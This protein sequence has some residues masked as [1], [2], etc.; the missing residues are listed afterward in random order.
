MGRK[1]RA[2]FNVTCFVVDAFIVRTVVEKDIFQP[3][4]CA[5]LKG[6]SIENEKSYHHCLLAFIDET[7]NKH[8]NTET[9]LNLILLYLIS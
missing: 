7:I 2:P 6:V 5:F 1:L 8:D 4:N 9:T 3:G